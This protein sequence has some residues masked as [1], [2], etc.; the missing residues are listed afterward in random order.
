M[1]FKLGL[2][3]SKCT[4]FTSLI[5]VD[6]YGISVSQMTTCRNTFRSFPHSRLITGCVTR[7]TRRATS[8][9]GTDTLPE[10]LSSPP[11]F[12]G[13]CVTRSFVLYVCFVDSCLSFCTFSFWPLCC[14]FFFDIWILITPLLYSNCS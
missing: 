2:N 4:L 7:L 1:H 11:V 14:L 12:S 3:Y 5:T 13:V 9:A 8:G 10:H 6:R